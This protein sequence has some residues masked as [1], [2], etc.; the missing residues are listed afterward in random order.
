MNDSDLNR[1]L[2]EIDEHRCLIEG[3]QVEIRRQTH[4]SDMQRRRI[5][6]LESEIEAIRLVLQRVLS[7]SPLRNAA[8]SNGHG[9]DIGAS[10][11][12]TAAT[13]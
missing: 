2:A 1:A 13:S 8:S 10:H 7:Q 3:Q 11:V 4:R 6:V 9:R 12:I 5:A